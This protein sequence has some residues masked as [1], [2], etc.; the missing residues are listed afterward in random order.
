MSKYLDLQQQIVHLFVDKSVMFEHSELDIAE[1]LL[2]DNGYHN[3][4][5]SSKV[6]FAEFIDEHLMMYKTIPFKEWQGYFEMDC[7]VSEHLKSNLTVFERTLNSRISDYVSGL[8]A[9]G[10]LS[11]FEKNEIIVKVRQN[12]NRK[13]V[14]FSKYNG[15]KSWF[16]ISEMTF[17]GMKQ[18]L[19]W[20]Y[21]NRRD[22]YF[23]IIEGFDFL[24]KQ[25]ENRIDELNNLRN[26]L[27]HNKPT[28]VYLIKGN[29]SDK[30]KI[31][32]RITAVKC[33]AELRTHRELS[34]NVND[35]CFYAKRYIDIK[36]SLLRKK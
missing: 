32:D 36:N 25:V 31:K 29:I 10:I 19:F 20:I 8:M 1:K 14:N 21:D 30:K 22:N 4:V 35:V 33:I 17:G 13:G 28:T 27:F 24:N 5:A 23:G 34:N 15:E 26:S 2:R 16:Y 7:Y 6:K 18:L 3:F 11:N 9:S 12:P